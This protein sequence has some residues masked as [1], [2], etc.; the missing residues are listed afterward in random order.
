[1]SP[2]SAVPLICRGKPKSGTMNENAHS[3]AKLFLIGSIRIVDGEG[4]DILLR[5]RKTRAVIAI[6]ALAEGKRVHRNRIAALLWDRSDTASAKMNLRH[7]IYEINSFINS[8]VPNLIEINREFIALS[9]GNCWI[10]AFD[11]PS[12]YERLLDDL[13][14]ISSAF[15]DWLE[16]ER[17]KFQQ[18]ERTIL[19][20]EL[21]ILVE[22]SAAPELRAV[23]AR[24]L[25]NLDA[26]HEVAVR[27]LMAAFTEMGDRAQA[28]REYER[29]R[30]ALR[31]KLDLLPSA[32]TIAAYEAIREISASRKTAA[33]SHQEAAAQIT[34]AKTVLK[35][36]DA[37][38]LGHQASI[39]VLPFLNLSREN[40][41]AHINDGLVEDLIQAL[42][43]VPNFFVISRLSSLAFQDRN[44]LPQEIGQALGVRY[45]ISGSIRVVGNCLRLTAE[46]TDT[47]EGAVLWNSRLDDRCF[48]LLEVQER[49]AHAIVR[50]VGPQ[51]HTAEL[52]RIR[53]KPLDDLG[54]YEVFLRAQESMHNSSRT[55]FEAAEWLFDEAIVRDPVYATALAWRAYWHVLR[56]GQGWS[57]DPAHDA[58]EAEHF[59][60]RAI[61]SDSAEPMAF[62]ISGHIAS[63]LHKDF[64][65]ASQYFATALDLNPNSAHA[66][67]W[68]AAAQ[69]WAGDGSRAIEEISK[70]IALSPYDPL[71]YAYSSIAAMAYL[72]DAQY[73]RA[74]EYALRSLRENSTYTSALRQLVM[75][76]QLAEKTEEARRAAHRLLILEPDLTVEKFRRRY[77]GSATPSADLYCGA[78]AKAGVPVSSIPRIVKKGAA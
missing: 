65:S 42:S 24:K 50:S 9:V 56:V 51:V 18:R 20:E 5:N 1:M 76:F 77:P 41:N 29:C 32:E 3:L 67:L 17:A 6:L 27:V 63:Y 40:S 2:S 43:R 37:T 57:A 28:T 55:A 13:G 54:A 33:S 12:H 53:T 15:D 73:E 19:E 36:P 8:K 68:S 35:Y 72:A 69:A 22:E 11:R 46:L 4:E 70:A 23:A 38:E 44:R 75:A 45:V 34:E 49:L 16:S 64:D 60:Q 74:I 59:A 31:S 71:M 62:A 66:W 52:K 47:R 25:V 21:R 14:G 10:D 58:A 61:E 26:T 78:L 30:E 7:S 39:A 48:D